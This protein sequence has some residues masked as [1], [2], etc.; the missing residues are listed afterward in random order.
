VA[1]RNLQKLTTVFA[2]SSEQ[3]GESGLEEWWK[4]KNQVSLDGQPTGIFED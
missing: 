3:K 2:A 1:C 4:E